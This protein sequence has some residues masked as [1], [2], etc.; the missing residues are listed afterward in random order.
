MSPDS[1]PTEL[2][3]VALAVAAA[4][5]LAATWDTWHGW[6]RHTVRAATALLCLSTT[7]TVALAWVNR[8][9][10]TY[11]TWADLFGRPDAAT[12]TTATPEGHHGG[13][14][15][16][17]TVPGTASGLN[18]PM[19]VY[20]PA[21]YDTHPKQRFPVIEALHGYP[22]SP[23]GWLQLLDAPGHLDREIAAG[24]MAPTIVLFPYQ[25][26]NTMVDTECVNLTHGPQSET[27]LTVDVPAW[28][29]THLRARA[30]RNAWGLTGLSA[31]G[32][33]ATNLLL[34]HPDRY[35]AAAS[36]SGYAEP[37]LTIGDGTEHTLNNDIWRL[38]HLPR[39]AVALYLSCGRADHNALRDTRALSRLARA[40]ISLTTSYVDGGG[41]NPSTWRAVEAPAF[42]WLSTWLGRPVTTA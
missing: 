35:A 27:F 17:V 16:T 19:Y 18:L 36:L 14:V 25:T 41:H 40:P 6:R 7:A 26:P 42:D 31:G 20:L 37:G 24:R 13:R 33:C 8:Q 38:Q 15:V 29:N 34:R 2:T 21:A 11:T 22:G 10:A 5:L 39:P 1:V 12:A 28:T 32:Y 9:S 3:A 23:A 4:V 30:N